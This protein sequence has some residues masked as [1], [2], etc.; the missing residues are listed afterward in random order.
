MLLYFIGPVKN[1]HTYFEAYLKFAVG[2]DS[3]YKND[4]SDIFGKCHC[5]YMYSVSS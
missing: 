4:I 3:A 5:G 1:I 2:R